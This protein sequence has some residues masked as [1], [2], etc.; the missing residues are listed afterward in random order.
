M[1]MVA[2]QTFSQLEVVFCILLSAF[3][4]IHPLL[5]Q[6]PTLPLFT[7]AMAHTFDEVALEEEE[8]KG[9]GN[10]G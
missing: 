8:E 7:P 1:S 10:R 9:G 6:Y 3:H 4:L 5:A 2:T